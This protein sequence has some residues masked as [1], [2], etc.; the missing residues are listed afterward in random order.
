MVDDVD[1]NGQ[2]AFPA[3]GGKLYRG[4]ITVPGII[5]FAVVSRILKA[6]A[7]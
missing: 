6:P 2:T 5:R 7:S 4:P 3:E 1:A